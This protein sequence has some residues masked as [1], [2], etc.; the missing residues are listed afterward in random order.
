MKNTKKFAAMIAA[1]T[2]SACSI[3]PMA[4][5]AS[6]TD[7]TYSISMNADG[8]EHT[9]EVYQLFTGTLT[10]VDGQNVLS[11]I[12]YGSSWD[13][14]QDKTAKEAAA[15]LEGMTS[16]EALA[17]AKSITLGTPIGQL[18]EENSYSLENMA[19]GYY[20][21]KDKDGSLTGKDEAYTSYI[22]RVVENVT[23]TPKSTK[24]TVDK[25][26]LDETTDAEAGATE[27]WGESA[28]HA[29]NETFQFKLIATLTPDENYADYETYQVQFNDTMGTGVTFDSIES[30][31][32]SGYTG[33]VTYTCDAKAGQEGDGE[34]P[35][36]IS[37]ADLKAYVD[38]LSDG[39]TVT[40]IYNAHLNESAAIAGTSD[41][42]NENN[43]ELEYSNN[44]NVSGSGENEH[45]KTPK[46]YVW[47]FTYKVDNTKV[48]GNQ[49]PLP[50]VEFQLLDSD[51]NVID[52][53]YDAD[54]EAYRPVKD[55]ETAET[56]TS[57]EATGKFNIVGLDAGNYKLHEV[58]PLP[59]YNAIDDVEIE[60]SATHEEN[61]DGAGATLDLTKSKNISNEIVNEKGSTL[62]ST[63]GIG[64]TI[65]YLGGGAM[66]AV[67][68]VF[69]ITKKRMG[70]SEN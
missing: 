43:V 50:G 27:G 41:D 16:A 66:V 2:L 54:L 67:A 36:S 64:T 10:E 4:M 49:D 46:D 13:G 9:Y 68:G 1:L 33:D 29:I 3:A 32:I 15:E 51:N 23:A 26:V 11:E 20:L 21:I 56:M 57:A 55:G 44:P 8:T 37:I 61:A 40:V 60:I 18:N 47:V 6:A 53:I 19:A 62:P 59:G 69:L 30:V 7:A 38:D 14:I 70:K 25:Q 17:W 52:L 65:F 12:E 58:A 48:D 45:G 63:G 34:T 42:V 5:T 35:W 39:A 24:P 22:L 28:D 31:T